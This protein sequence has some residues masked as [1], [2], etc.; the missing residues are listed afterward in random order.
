MAHV[1]SMAYA[2]AGGFSLEF[3]PSLVSPARSF[4]GGVD[5]CGRIY[6]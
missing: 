3:N 4:F 5:G 1:Y 6:K 2:G